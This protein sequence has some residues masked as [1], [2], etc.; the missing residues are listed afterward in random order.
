MHTYVSYAAALCTRNIKGVRALG[1]V[2]RRL[3]AYALAALLAAG[4]WWAYSALQ[5]RRGG[6]RG[7][8]RVAV[9]FPSLLEDVKA[10]ACEGDVVEPVAPAGVD[11]HEYQLTP[12]DLSMLAESD[13]IV[14]TG[15]TPFEARIAELVRR[16]ELKARLIELPSIPGIR[17]LTNP[18]TGQPNYHMPILDPRNYVAFVRNLTETMAQLRPACAQRYRESGRRIVEEVEAL[19]ARA[20]R[21]NV[22]ALGLS[23]V[24]QY[25]V[26]WMGIHVKYLLVKEHEVPSTP[27]D[28]AAAERGLASGEVK[29]VVLVR[30]A[31]G[32]P[33]GAKARELA[34]RYGVPILYVPSPIGPEGVLQ[35][36]REAVR[37]VEELIGK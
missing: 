23:P 14:S 19:A 8:L 6:E 5:A 24:V 30:G 21:L 12:R 3:I 32:T 2:S 35:K 33:L 10:V 18:A 15:H 1:A 20:P 16:G 27:E 4:A 7:G 34:S 22:T 31:E 11:P 9:T 17:L 13:L 28:I 37:G 36:I 25:Q 29:L 26:E